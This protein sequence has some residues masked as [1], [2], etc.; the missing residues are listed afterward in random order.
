M[1]VFVS[2][3]SIFFLVSSM[4]RAQPTGKTGEIRGRVYHSESLEGLEGTNIMLVST[5]MGTFAEKNGFFVLRDVPAGDYI[6]VTSFIGFKKEKKEITVFADQVTEINILLKPTT[7]EIGREIVVIGKRDELSAIDNLLEQRLSNTDE[8]LSSIEGVSIIRRG[9]AFSDPVIR[10][11]KEGRVNVTLDGVKIF[12]ACPGRMDPPTSYLEIGELENI[13]VV[14]GPNSVTMGA[15]CLGGCINLISKRPEPSSVLSLSGGSEVAYYSAPKGKKGKL[16]LSG[17]ANH[18]GFRLNSTYQDYED[19]HSG[20]SLILHSSFKRTSY[21]AYL[22]LYPDKKK[23]IELSLLGNIGNNTGYPALPMDADED[24][25]LIGSAGYTQ[26]NLSKNWSRFSTKVYYSEVDHVMSNVNR[27]TYSM[28]QMEAIGQTRTFGG[29][30]VSDFKFSE[31]EYKTGLDFYETNGDATRTISMMMKGMPMTM[32]SRIWPDATIRDLGLFGEI[33]AFVTSRVL[34]KIGLRGDFSKARADEAENGFIN[35]W[36]LGSNP[37]KTG[38]NLSGNLSLTY[39][40]NENLTTGGSV[41]R[42]NR[43]PEVGEYYSFFSINRLDNYDYIGNPELSNESN[44]NFELKTIMDFDVFQAKVSGFWNL[45]DNYIVGRLSP[46]DT[47]KTMGANGV[48]VYENLGQAEIKGIEGSWRLRLPY[49]FRLLGNFSYSQGDDQEND[50]PLPEIPPFEST[51]GLKYVNSKNEY[52]VQV[53]GR[54]VAEQNRV[55][56]LTGEDETPSSRV[57]DVRAGYPIFEQLQIYAGVENILDESYFE[58]LNRNNIP[59]QGRN[60]YLSLKS[61]F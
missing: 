17:G 29:N 54:F 3:L 41:A 33:Q 9:N 19:Y 28:M 47:A 12:G 6:L 16:E 34:S 50:E 21:G 60:I 11:L 43:I 13:E 18:Y 31:I 49:G 42:G 4:A 46:D 37:S 10:G 24:E 57:F 20:D 56:T 52:W 30:A 32:T 35:Y 22:D 7:V 51:L 40:I 45:I 1:K 27:P 61:G 14:K 26:K 38:T 23:T 36:N 48:K 44:V 55:S 8:L 2:L 58:H 5:P 53:N 59:S 39:K 25:G 15:N